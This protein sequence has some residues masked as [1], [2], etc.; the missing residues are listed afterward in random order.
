MSRREIDDTAWPEAGAHRRLLELLD[1]VHRDNGLKSR[2]TIAEKMNLKA[3]SY[4]NDMLRGIRR[5][6]DAKQLTDLIRALGGGAE[7]IEAGRRLFEKVL[8]ESREQRSPASRHSWGRRVAEHAAW[9]LAGNPDFQEHSVRIA[10][11][12]AG[13]SRQAERVLDGD[14][15]R[16]LDGDPLDADLADRFVKWTD[17]L[18][19]T[20]LV[21]ELGELSPAEATLLALV[22]LLHHTHTVRTL[23]ALREIGPLDFGDGAGPARREYAV[24]CDG[25]RELVD[26]A[27]APVLQDRPHAGIEIGWWLFHRWVARFPESY[28]LGAIREFL[29]DVRI[30]DP[31]IRDE[32][33]DARVLQRFLYGLRLDPAELADADRRNA[34][35]P[36]SFLFAGE[37]HEQRVRETLLGHVLAVAYA[38]ALDLI[39]LPDIVVRHLGIPGSV[40]L[41]RLRDTVTRRANWVL[42]SDCLVLHA[43]CHHPAELEGLRQYARQVDTLLYS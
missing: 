28:G 3:A 5:P 32:V 4:I 10:E 19:R 36:E 13:L 14:P 12:L 6:V 20:A 23:A 40:D 7:D 22:P 42:D 34:L 8:T 2:R 33:L 30:S 26:R 41:R 43:N 29:K 37:H 16:V 25:Q 31:R 15:W 18:V 17:W 24:F 9:P 27:R 38:L 1:R 21:D 11:R 35:E 39:R